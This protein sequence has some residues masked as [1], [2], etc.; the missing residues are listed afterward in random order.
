M[1]SLLWDTGATF[2]VTNG[3]GPG[4]ATKIIA[5]QNLKQLIKNSKDEKEEA[6]HIEEIELKYVTSFETSLVIFFLKIFF[7]ANQDRKLQIHHLVHIWCHLIYK[8]I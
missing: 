6:D 3:E 7:G 5:F 8:E 4:L 1:Y 2:L